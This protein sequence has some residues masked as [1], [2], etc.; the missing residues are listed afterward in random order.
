MMPRGRNPEN[1]SPYTGLKVPVCKGTYTQE[2][3]GLML[4][5]YTMAIV[6]CGNPTPKKQHTGG[7]EWPT[8]RTARAQRV[9]NARTAHGTPPIY[10]ENSEGQHAHANMH[11][12]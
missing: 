8:F 9:H 2:G 1:V 3:G 6:P 11:R 12:D 4:Q 5:G 10:L 7:G